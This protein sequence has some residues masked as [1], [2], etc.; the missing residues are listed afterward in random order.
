MS[1]EIF[2]FTATAREMGVFDTNLNKN[3]DADGDDW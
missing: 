2:F 3:D 1:N